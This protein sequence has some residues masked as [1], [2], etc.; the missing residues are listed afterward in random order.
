M[1]FP[2]TGECI[3]L[4]GPDQDLA[5][6]LDRI[7]QLETELRSV[8][9]AVSDE[10]LARMDQ[11]ASWT[12]H[13]GDLTLTGQSPDRTEY[14]GARLAQTVD[15]LVAGGHITSEAAHA[16][17]ESEVT[18]KVKKAGVNKLLK[19]GGV[20]AESVSVCAAPDDRPRRITVKK[21]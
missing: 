6:A 20:V 9:R 15:T 10:L 5:G 11:A 14:D 16:A 2:V 1:P 4:A 17:V 18:W 21:T 12:I 13:A 7:R 8:K 19:L 3:D